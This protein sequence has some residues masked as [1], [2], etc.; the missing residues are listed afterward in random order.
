MSGSGSA[1]YGIF[2]VG[3][4]LEK[5]KWPEGYKVKEIRDQKSEKTFF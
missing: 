2:E 1:V 4:S 5:L 3:Q